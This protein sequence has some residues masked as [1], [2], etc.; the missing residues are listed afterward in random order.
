MDSYERSL[1][2]I[3][4]DIKKTRVI[5]SSRA[6][7]LFYNLCRTTLSHHWKVYHSVNL[8]QFE[9]EDGL[10]DNEMDFVLYHPLYGIFVVEVKGGRIKYDAVQQQF[11]SINRHGESFAIKDPFKQAL[12]WKSRFLRLLK[13]NDMKVPVTH[14]VCFPSVTAKNFASTAG[15][16]SGLIMGRDEINDMERYL[17]KTAKICHPTHFLQFRDVGVELDGLI[18]GKSFTSKLYIRDYIDG[19][20]LRV[21]DVETI[22][23]SLVTP[24][25]SSR[26]IGVEGEAGTGKTMLA[27]LIAKHFRDLSKKVLLLSSNP[28]LNLFLKQETGEG[29]EVETYSG[30]A[31][32]HGVNLL[33]PPTGY[34]GSR[35]DWVQI[36]GPVLL[37]DS[38]AAKVSEPY[39][40]IICDEAQ[41]VQPFWWEAFEELLNTETGCLYLFFDRSQGI[42]GSGGLDRKFNPDDTLPISPPFFPLVHNYRTTR[43]ISGFARP[44][45]TGG[46]VLQS[47]CGRLGYSP[48]LVVYKD[49]EDCIRQL[50]KIVRTLTRDEKIKSE[51]ITLLS[52]RDPR[53]KE[54]VLAGHDEIAKF[55]IHRLIFNK[56]KQWKQTRAPAGH[57]SVATISAFK[58]LE[59]KIGILINLSEYNLPLSNPIMSS[60]VYVAC[61]RAKHMLYICV[62]EGDP[63]LK[64]LEDALSRIKS[65]GALVLEGSEHDF[66]FTGRVSHYNPS[67][68]GWLTVEDAAFQKSTIMF[69]PSD[70]EKNGLEHDL[71]VGVKLKFRPKVEGP[72]TIASDLKLVV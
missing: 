19:H 37:K 17:S 35:S 6:E 45:R 20:E 24:I 46:N 48:K 1:V 70:V 33:N 61:T 72:I 41:D 51:E 10:K 9:G 56:K 22:Y 47:H 16:N 44:F 2:K 63:K 42:F 40:V 30:I 29:I 67:R 57:L 54:S 27:L 31:E 7:E 14:L 71:K 11:Y 36:D 58:G 69:F 60:L 64:E 3:Y 32:A 65:A 18:V 49:K 39:D 53:S 38:I 21:R 62:K 26:K 4:P 15:I 28:I 43:E 25:T 23:D 8:S 59:T 52:A 13:K 66:E 5:F 34:E 12:V 50:V 68:C 55:P